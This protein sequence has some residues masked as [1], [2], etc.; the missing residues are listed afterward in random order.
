MIRGLGKWGF[1]RDLTFMHICE[2]KHRPSVMS[3]GTMSGDMWLAQPTVADRRLA[4]T[5]VFRYVIYT[6]TCIRV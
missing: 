2:A 1:V 5:P 3:R 6:G 4:S